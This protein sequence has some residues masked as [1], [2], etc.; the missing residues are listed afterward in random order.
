MTSNKVNQLQMLR[1]SLESVVMQK[2][3]IESSLIEIDSAISQLSSSNK[4][5]KIIGKIMIES[6]N[7]DLKKELEEKK[8]VIQIRLKNF[9]SQEEKIK[10]DMEELQKEVVAQLKNDSSK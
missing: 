9:T 10:K 8:E 4:S 2:Q 7:D 6:S 1:Q 5:F 3:Q